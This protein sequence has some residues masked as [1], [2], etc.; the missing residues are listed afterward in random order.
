MTND[1]HVY[2][3]LRLAE[4]LGY[5][6]ACGIAAPTEPVIV[7]P[8]YL[9]REVFALVKEILTGNISL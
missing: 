5:T 4:G 3:A 8:H 1:F 9:V 6:E 2:R 7:E